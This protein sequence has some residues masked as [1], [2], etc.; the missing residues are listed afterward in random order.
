[1][2]HLW[3][4]RC[5]SSRINDTQTSCLDSGGGR[6]ILGHRILALGRKSKVV[7]TTF[8]SQ[9]PLFKPKLWQNS[10]VKIKVEQ[11]RGADL[12]HSPPDFPVSFLGKRVP[13]RAPSFYAR[14]SQI[15]SDKPGLEPS[16]AAWTLPIG[17]RSLVWR[18]LVKISRLEKSDSLEACCIGLHDALKL[19]KLRFQST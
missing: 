12:A 3:G 1:M 11:L 6:G 17:H 16:S 5:G 14:V 13:F 9:T 10:D 19:W 15:P 7:P 2:E 8:C 18:L 4:F